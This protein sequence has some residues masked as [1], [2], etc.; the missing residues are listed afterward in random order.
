MIT[1]AFSIWSI[2]STLFLLFQNNN[3]WLMVVSLVGMIVSQVW[4]LCCNG[5][6][7]YP[8]NMI[9]LAIFTLCESYFVSFICGL[10]ANSVGTQTVVVAAVMTMAMV[11]ACTVYAY[12]TETDFT[13]SWALVTVLSVVLLV[14]GL[15]TMFTS[16][17]F[18]TN[19]YCAVGVFVFGLYLII[20]TQM[21]MGGRKAE[22]TT[23]DYVVAAL[24][25][26]ID[27]IQIFLYILELLKNNND[28]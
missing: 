18:L 27:I 16:S 5:G 21:I 26:Y 13:A 23:D 28:N 6:R 12:K 22:M 25:L 11:T 4:I 10:T 2:N 1:G 20:D 19:L 8:K 15:V 3:M 7:D 24:M 17:P 9:L 14:L